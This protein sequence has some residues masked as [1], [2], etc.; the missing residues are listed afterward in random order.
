MQAH[1]FLLLIFIFVTMISCSS[2]PVV[3][4][5][6]LAEDAQVRR[7]MAYCQQLAARKVPEGRRIARQAG[8]GAILGGVL[9]GL[10]GISQG[11]APKRI[12]T[13]AAL[14]G[15]LSGTQSA[16]YPNS[17]RRRYVETCLRRRGHQII[18]W[19]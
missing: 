2:Q 16:V 5:D 9:G 13:G 14:G 19:N 8:R 12:L 11:Q 1:H 10:A 7:D 4:S 3:Y 15:G 6:S 17:T 18:G